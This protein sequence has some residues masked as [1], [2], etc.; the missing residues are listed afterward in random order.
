M[1]EECCTFEILATVRQ[2]AVVGKTHHDD[3][4]VGD[5]AAD[6]RAEWHEKRAREIAQVVRRTSAREAPAAMHRPTEFHTTEGV[7]LLSKL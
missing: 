4:F 3:K 6:A 1:H 2:N 5:A 7:P